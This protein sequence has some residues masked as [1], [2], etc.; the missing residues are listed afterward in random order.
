MTAVCLQAFSC[1][2]VGST[3]RLAADFVT[4]CDSSHTAV[5]VV[6][7]LCLIVAAAS[8]PLAL[9][10]LT[11]RPASAVALATFVAPMAPHGRGWEAGNL[12]RALLVTGLAFNGSV[13]TVTCSPHALRSLHCGIG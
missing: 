2:S 9:L 3:S 7:A 1:V 6:A 8:V 13:A 11:R 5:T 12:V 4:P 10:I